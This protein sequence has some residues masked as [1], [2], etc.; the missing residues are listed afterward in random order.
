M[1]IAKSQRKVKNK[2][3]KAWKGRTEEQESVKA[4]KEQLPLSCSLFSLSQG[5]VKLETPQGGT[6]TGQSVTAPRKK[7]THVAVESL[8]ETKI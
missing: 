2:A 7:N 3:E 1:T 5:Q 4:Q 8:L 6:E